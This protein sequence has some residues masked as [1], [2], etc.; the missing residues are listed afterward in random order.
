MKV[1]NK[2]KLKKLDVFRA[3]DQPE[4]CSQCS[5]RTDFEN[6][7]EIQEYH[8]CLNCGFEF[9]LDHTEDYYHEFSVTFDIESTMDP[10][11][12]PYAEL[13]RLCGDWQTTWRKIQ[14]EMLSNMKMET[15]TNSIFNMR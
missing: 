3:T 12:I 10:D 14:I 13:I 7:N 5:S 9:I 6:I 11:D 4:E 1:P 2:K 15:L 8:E